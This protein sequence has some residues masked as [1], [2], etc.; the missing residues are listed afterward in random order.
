MGALDSYLKRA[1]PLVTVNLAELVFKGAAS[2]NVRRV[3]S[4]LSRQAPLIPI[5]PG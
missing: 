5:P 4:P 2:W 3:T 1:C